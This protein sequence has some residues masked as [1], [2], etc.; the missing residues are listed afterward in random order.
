MV[1][2]IPLL[3][4]NLLRAKV[5]QGPT[6]KISALSELMRTYEFHAVWNLAHILKPDPLV[7]W[8][9]GAFYGFERL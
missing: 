4:P 9:H 1:Q 3:E 8:K 2:S 5:I 7:D 6:R